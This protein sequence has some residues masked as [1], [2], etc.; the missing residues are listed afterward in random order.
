M[1]SARVLT[2]CYLLILTLVVSGCDSGSPIGSAVGSYSDVAI[3]TETRL[4][5]PVA[6]QL[7]KSLSVEV[8]YAI[9]PEPLFNV[10]VFDWQDRRNAQVYKNLII[11]GLLEGDDPASRELRRRLGGAVLSDKG[12][13]NLFVAVMSNTYS[14][15]QL[16]YFVAGRDRGL[17]QS[18]LA[19]NI[20]ILVD[21][22]SQENRKRILNYLFTN[23]HELDL[24]NKIRHQMHFGL[25]VPAS[26][27]ETSFHTGKH[28]GFVEVAAV[29][30]TRAVGIYYLDDAEST[31]IEDK[32]VLLDLR[33][34]F[35]ERFLDEELQDA[36]GYQW[37]EVN[38]AGK[39]LLTLSGFW[40]AKKK[41]YGGPFRT[42]FL[43]EKEKRRLYGINLLTYAPGMRKHP[44]IREAMAVA[45]T[46]KP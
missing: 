8:T 18:S 7:K 12:H 41:D 22:I 20:Q 11:I 42:F 19:R 15:N 1:R 13:K 23:G 43:Y 34:S 14:R 38:F 40:Q 2:F 24:E 9:K 36:G 32:E 39:R 46:L 29:R 16:V 45:E 30:P 6:R 10:D 28:D 25:E 27:R 4:L 26:Y 37:S 3:L 21:R 5:G 31:M 44:Y 35:G 17:M 33:R